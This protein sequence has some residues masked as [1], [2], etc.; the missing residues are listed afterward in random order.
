MIRDED[1]GNVREQKIS[2]IVSRML[3]DQ[4]T[5]TWNRG[6]VL[7]NSRLDENDI[8]SSGCHPIIIKPDV[9]M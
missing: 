1:C 5:A 3:P 6:P 7:C 9:V 8:V 4:S 2:T